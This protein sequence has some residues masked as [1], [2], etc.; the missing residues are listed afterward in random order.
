MLRNK[1]AIIVWLAFPAWAKRGWFSTVFFNLNVPV[2]WKKHGQK[3]T[4]CYG[5][6]LHRSKLRYLVRANLLSKSNETFLMSGLKILPGAGN[7]VPVPVG[8][9]V[10]C[11]HVVNLPVEPLAPNEEGR[12]AGAAAPVPLR[13]FKEQRLEEPLDRPILHER[14]CKIEHLFKLNKNKNIL[15]R[16]KTDAKSSLKSTHRHCHTNKSD[17]VY[18]TLQYVPF[19]L[20]YGI[21]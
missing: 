10:G 21:G 18:S 17:L 12:S 13:H 14:H 8:W 15:F 1:S 16:Y 19:Y 9:W 7:T 3:K 20:L 11:Q 4:C 6:K 2:L 5:L